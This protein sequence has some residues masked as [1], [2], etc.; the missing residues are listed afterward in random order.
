MTKNMAL[1]KLETEQIRQVLRASL[2][3]HT[4]V[5][6]KGRIR[7]LFFHVV[8]NRNLPVNLLNE[9]PFLQTMLHNNQAKQMCCIR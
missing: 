8:R 2:A 5:M 1:Y 7:E 6:M 3:I 4:Y 9:L